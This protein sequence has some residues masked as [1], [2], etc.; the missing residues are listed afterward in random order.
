LLTQVRFLA[1]AFATAGFGGQVARNDIGAELLLL[2]STLSLEL[3]ASCY[4]ALPILL[5]PNSELRLTA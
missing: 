4:S 1:S 3:S 2:L 5:I